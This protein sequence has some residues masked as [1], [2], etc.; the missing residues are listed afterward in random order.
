MFDRFFVHFGIVIFPLLFYQLWAFRKSFDRLPYATPI[1]GLYG[2]LSAVLSEMY[3]L[4]IF[5]MAEDMKLIPIILAFLYGKRNAGLISV[6]I[7]AAYRLHAGHS[8]VLLAV[9]S[10]LAYSVPPLLV[11]KR[12]DGY[13]SARRLLV[14]VGLALSAT[15]IQLLFVFVYF[16]TQAPN[17]GWALLQPYIQTLVP[18]AVVQT[19]LMLPAVFV[20][21]NIVEA[22]RVHLQLVE[23]QKSLRESEERYR[24]LVEYN[25]EGIC[26][27]DRQGQILFVNKAYEEITGYSTEELV[28]LN[29]LKVWFAEDEELAQGISRRALN[30]EVLSNMDVHLRHRQGDR[31]PVRL[32][33]VPLIVSGEPNGYYA[34]VTDLRPIRRA[35]EMMQKLDKLSTV[36]ELAAGVAHEIRNPLTSLKGF[37]KLLKT[38]DPTT[39]RYVSIMEHEMN[40]LDL[41]SG[42]M[43]VLA[44]PQVETK[45][46][47]DVSTVVR[48]VIEIMRLQALLASISI[49]DAV[50]IQSAFVI[51]DANQLK[52]V[53]INVTKNAL[54]ATGAGGTITIGLE[55]QG[56][57]LV[58]VVRDTGR[59][60]PADMVK[61]LGE[62]FYTTKSSGTGLGLMVCHRIIEQHGGDIRYE[63]QEGVGT[64]VTI[65]LPDADVIHVEAHARSVKLSS[66]M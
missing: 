22:G 5:G 42:Q 19:L 20:L 23:S 1:V 52:Q 24:S 25:P 65:G 49:E 32:T 17:H 58:M 27:I 36:G 38:H 37:L 50:T 8:G 35:E 10:I 3:P 63:S 2:G 15:L 14:S 56:P 21:D 54:E 7:V 61:R 53:L 47:M 59:G 62:P 28:G 6:A 41:V 9:I 51:A 43:L 18:A 31:I 33:I 39:K 57:V 13:S 26:A 55:R 30:G 29:R 46:R 64:T 11:S 60:M 4:H 34:V 45:K 66:S 44:K 12:F 48:E 40:R 16:D